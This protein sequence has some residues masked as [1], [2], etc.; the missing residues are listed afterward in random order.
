[1]SKLVEQKIPAPSARWIV[2]ISKTDCVIHAQGGVFKGTSCFTSQ[3]LRLAKSNGEFEI[4][5]TE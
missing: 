5:N 1:M 2:A 4:V 3:D